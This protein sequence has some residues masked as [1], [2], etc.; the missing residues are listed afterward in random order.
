MGMGIGIGIG[1]GIG[2]Y[3]MQITI[4]TKNPFIDC[5]FRHTHYWKVGLVRCRNQCADCMFPR[6]HRPQVHRGEQNL[7]EQSQAI[8][9]TLADLHFDFSRPPEPK[10]S[11]VP[12]K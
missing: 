8:H 4:W 3:A 11:E 6:Y 9:R 2:Y 5:D 10:P 1:I 7:N 12:P